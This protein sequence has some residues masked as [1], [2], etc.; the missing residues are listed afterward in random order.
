[1]SSCFKDLFVHRKEWQS[2]FYCVSIGKSTLVGCKVVSSFVRR[3]IGHGIASRKGPKK[4]KRGREPW[5][6]GKRR[7]LII[8]RL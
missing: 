4:E 3:S 8:R 6:S 7:R 5:S 2:I 1:M